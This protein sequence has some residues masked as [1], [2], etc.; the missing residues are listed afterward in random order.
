[1]VFAAEQSDC[2]SILSTLFGLA[3]PLADGMQKVECFSVWRKYYGMGG[4]VLDS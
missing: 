4:F 3:R 2:V 1:M